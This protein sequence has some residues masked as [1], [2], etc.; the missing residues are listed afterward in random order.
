MG[1][2]SLELVPEAEAW[3]GSVCRGLDR[4]LCHPGSSGGAVGLIKGRG[5]SAGPGSESGTG[6]P[7]LG[8]LTLEPLLHPVLGVVGVHPAGHSGWGESQAS[9][10]LPL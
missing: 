1:P 6:I 4:A 3:Q 8:T 9:G 10:S 5:Q 7:W 2:G